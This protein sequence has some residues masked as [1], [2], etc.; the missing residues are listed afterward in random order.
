[1][2]QVRA[3]NGWNASGPPGRGHPLRCAEM[4]RSLLRIDGCRERGGDLS[5][6]GAMGWG[7]SGGRFPD[8]VMSPRS[9]SDVEYW[10]GVRAVAAAL[11][12]WS[13][14]KGWRSGWGP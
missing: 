8:R 9:R 13:T 3:L 10:S 1:V 14:L 11:A 5:R 2:D 4:N 7:L 12:S 6:K